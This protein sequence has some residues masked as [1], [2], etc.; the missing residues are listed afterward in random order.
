MFW[1]VQ[2][3]R[4]EHEISIIRTN[5]GGSMIRQVDEGKYK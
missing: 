5:M 4:M 3:K 2:P 1:A